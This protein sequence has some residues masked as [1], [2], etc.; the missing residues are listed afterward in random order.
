MPNDRQ[1]PPLLA[2][3]NSGHV[4]LRDG[5]FNFE[6]DDKNMKPMQPMNLCK[7]KTI[8]LLLGGNYPVVFPVEQSK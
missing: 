7:L 5:L 8:M 3:T 2:H 1:S 4:L 6:R